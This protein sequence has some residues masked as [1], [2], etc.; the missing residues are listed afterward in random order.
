MKHVLMG[1]ILIRS[2]GVEDIVLRER[3]VEIVRNL[4]QGVVR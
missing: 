3:I 1:T 4:V 2:R